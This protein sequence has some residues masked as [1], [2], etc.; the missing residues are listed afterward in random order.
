MATFT[1][2]HIA[3][4]EGLRLLDLLG[5]KNDLARCLSMIDAIVTRS[6]DGSTADALAVAILTV[7]GRIFLG[8]VRSEAKIPAGKILS[9]D[10]M[11]IHRQFLDMR[12][13]HIAHSVNAMETP[14]LRVWLNPEERGGRKINNVN[15][16]L[17]ML[18]TL[19]NSDYHHLRGFCVK[20]KAWVEAEEELEQS[21]LKG[22]IETEYTLDELYGM[23]ADVAR[24]GGLDDVSKGRAR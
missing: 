18:L 1:S 21:R 4:R 11:I 13:K 17:T 9:S 7:Y 6:H 20:L 12:S 24:A 19:S 5:V 8:G 2:V 23:R 15:A 10:E 3:H 16:D 14:K 22:I